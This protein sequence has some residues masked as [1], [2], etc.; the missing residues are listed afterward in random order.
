MVFREVYVDNSPLVIAENKCPVLMLRLFQFDLI[1][2]AHSFRLLE[3]VTL[4]Q[5]NQH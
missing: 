5:A 3:W 1:Q 2:N 4:N